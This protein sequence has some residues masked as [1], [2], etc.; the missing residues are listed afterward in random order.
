MP[1]LIADH[2]A[3]TAWLPAHPH[4]IGVRAAR[5]PRADGEGRQNLS[6]GHPAHS[7]SLGQEPT[8]VFERTR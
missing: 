2:T 3:V 1:V 7:T 8:Q 5:D 4:N 6:Q